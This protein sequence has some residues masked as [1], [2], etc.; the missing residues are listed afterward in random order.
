MVMTVSPLFCAEKVTRDDVAASRAKGIFS[1]IRRRGERC[2]SSPPL[3]ESPSGGRF[4]GIRFNGQK[5]SKSRTHGKVTSIG[6]DIRPSAKKS[7]AS[8]YRQ[9]DGR[10]T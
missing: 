9:A 1:R 8:E 7:S 6:L 2:A 4:A 10:S 5:S 3:S